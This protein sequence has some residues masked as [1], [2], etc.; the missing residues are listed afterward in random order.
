M[1]DVKAGTIAED[2]VHQ[3]G[4]GLVSAVQFQLLSA[5]GQGDRFGV[6][7]WR[8]VRQLAGIRR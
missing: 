2:H 7:H 6:E 3:E 8:L 5:I 1:I 4:T